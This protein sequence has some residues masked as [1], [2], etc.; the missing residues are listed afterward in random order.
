MTRAFCV[1]IVGD[2]ARSGVREAA[3]VRTPMQ[4]FAASAIWVCVNG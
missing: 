1:H 4:A 3:G 2:T